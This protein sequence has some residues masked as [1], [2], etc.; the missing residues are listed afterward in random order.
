M[1]HPDHRDFYLTLFIII[2]GS[3]LCLIDIAYIPYSMYNQ[4]W[5]KKL[6]LFTSFSCYIK[7]QWRAM[8]TNYWKGVLKLIYMLYNNNYLSVWIVSHGVFQLITAN[9]ISL[10][11]D[12]NKHPGGDHAFSNWIH[13]SIHCYSVQNLLVK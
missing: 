7:K 6:N 2:F 9:R 1:G 8:F 13:F 3:K 12:K 5:E 4:N 11:L 10:K